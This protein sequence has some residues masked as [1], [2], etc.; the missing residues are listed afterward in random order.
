[1]VSANELAALP[2]ELLNAVRRNASFRP[3]SP[4]PVLMCWTSEFATPLCRGLSMTAA[5]V[6]ARIRGVA[7]L[8][9]WELQG[10]GELLPSDVPSAAEASRDLYHRTTTDLVNSGT[11]MNRLSRVRSCRSGSNIFTGW[12]R[13]WWRQ[14]SL[15]AMPTKTY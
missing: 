12:S 8:K 4:P 1:M 11:A 6:S 14:K 13:D 7:Q 9:H 2:P 5:S 15:S 10:L 3:I